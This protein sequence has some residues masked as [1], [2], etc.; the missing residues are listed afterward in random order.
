M[1]YLI[2]IILVVISGCSTTQMRGNLD[3]GVYSNVQNTFEMN[4]PF[5]SDAKITDG[6]MRYF[7]YVDFFIENKVYS[8]EVFNRAGPDS[9]DS[10]RSGTESFMKDY[11]PNKCGPNSFESV[12]GE[13]SK[14][15]NNLSYDFVTLG[16]RPNGKKT[17]LHGRSIYLAPNKV[18]IC[19]L[20]KDRNENEKIEFFKSTF[21][22]SEFDGVCSSIKIKHL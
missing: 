3:N 20:Y 15:S 22:K 18:A 19:M 7:S 4:V 1:H 17:F 14:I 13:F 21:D 16:I 9:E 8:I 5:L 2:F 10:F 12:T 11:I 6:N